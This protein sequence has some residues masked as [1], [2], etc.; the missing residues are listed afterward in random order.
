MVKEAAAID[1]TDAPDAAR[2]KLLA[3]VAD[4]EDGAEVAERVSAAI[5][6]GA[7]AR[8]R[9]HPGDVLGGA[10]AARGPRGADAARRRVRRHPL[11]RADVPRPARVRRGGS[12][13]THP[14][15]LVCIARP[16]LLR[17]PSGLGPRWRDA[18]RRSSRSASDQSADL[19]DEPARARSGSPPTS[20]RGSPRRPRATRCSSRRC[21]RMLIDEGL[22]ERDDGHWSARGDLAEV[23]V[24]RRSTPC[25]RR[26]S[27]SLELEERAVIERGR[28]R[29]Q[30]LLLGRGDASCSPE[31]DRPR[32]GSHLQTLAAQGA[33]PPGS[34]R[35]SPG[36]DAFRFSHI[37]IRDAAYGAMP[38][39][40]A[41]RPAR[42]LRRLAR[43]RGGRPDRR[44]RGDR[45]LPPRARVPVPRPSSDRWTMRRAR[46]PRRPPNGWP[47][48]AAGRSRT[49]T[50]RRPRTCCREPWTSCRRTI[51]ADST[52]CETLD[53]ARAVRHPASGGRPDRGGRGRSGR[54]RPPLGGSR[55]RAAGLR[56][57]AAETR[58]STSWRRSPRSRATSGGSSSGETTW[59]S[60]RA[61]ASSA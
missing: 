58:T 5:G 28:G 48:P 53:G 59:V 33:R 25:S 7:K 45:R 56:P 51:R 47:R 16:E 22:L 44:V 60:P 27:I 19:I 42:A 57:A 4:A 3:L 12:A 61:A 26:G 18:D 34:R 52:S 1:E 29:R 9:G 21:S 50:S 6:L 41:G 49:G 24:P 37:L 8:A 10:P 20:G 14:L 35:R 43:A 15:L 17:D 38:K 2:A 32:V 36:E 23:A 30:G 46:S 39:R 40:V 13:R 55:R 31:D 54:R 11:G